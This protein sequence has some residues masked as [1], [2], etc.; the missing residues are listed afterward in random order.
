MPSDS[1]NEMLDIDRSTLISDMTMATILD[2]TNEIEAYERMYPEKSEDEVL[3][4][5]RSKRWYYVSKIPEFQTWSDWFLIMV[6]NGVCENLSFYQ[7]KMTD[8]EFKLIKNLIYK[9]MDEFPYWKSKGGYYRQRI[10]FRQF[11]T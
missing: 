7:I 11:V 5:I 4:L 6:M 8:E 2:L 10:G 1:K 3:K 9:T